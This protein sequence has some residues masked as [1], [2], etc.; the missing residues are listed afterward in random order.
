MLKP[1]TGRQAHLSSITSINSIILVD[2]KSN[3]DRVQILLQERDRDDT[4]KI[5]IIKLNNLSSVEAVRIL[6]KL[7]LQS[8]PTINNFIAIPFTQS[9]SVILSANKIVSRNVESTLRI[10]D[11]DV[12]NDREKRDHDG[13]RRDCL[14]AGIRR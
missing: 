13:R 7:K 10:L 1:I 2:R 8:N 12:Q 14:V 3:V 9:N 6:D 4:A 5:S 11:E